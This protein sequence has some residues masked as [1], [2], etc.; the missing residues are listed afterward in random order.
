MSGTATAAIFPGAVLQ[1]LLSDVP[2]PHD[3]NK[4]IY[5]GSANSDVYVCFVRADAPVKTFQDTLSTELIVGASSDGATTRDFPIM[6]NNVLGTKFKL[7]MGYPGSRE[8]TLAMERGEVQGVCG[9][10]WTGI[11]GLEEVPRYL[12]VWLVMLGAA[13]AMYR[14]EHTTLEYFINLLRPRLRALVLIVTNAV[15]IGLF[16]Y[17]IKSGFVLVPNAQLQTSPGLG[18][19]LGYVYAAI[20]IGAA[21]IAL[22][23][24]R[25]IYFALRSLWQRRS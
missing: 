4:L 8:I 2:V 19:S 7:V 13:A 6:L 10:G 23:M 14:G 5:L 17:L 22:P 15:G 21:L 16:V 1:P 18:L 12:F 20:P 3:P 24:L 11:D 25:N 9:I